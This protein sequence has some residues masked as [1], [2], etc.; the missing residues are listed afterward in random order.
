[1]LEMLFL[2]QHLVFRSSPRGG[3]E[4]SELWGQLCS[5]TGWAHTARVSARHFHKLFHLI[6]KNI[7]QEWVIISTL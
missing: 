7:N 5:E 6:F 2:H 1:M 3:N 4:L